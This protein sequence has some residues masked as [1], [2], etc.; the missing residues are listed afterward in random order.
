VRAWGGIGLAFTLWAAVG[1]VAAAPTRCPAANVVIDAADSG[2][3]DAGCRAAS[4]AAEFLAASG[5]ATGIPIEIWFVD[6]M[7]D[8][9][10]DTP[11]VGCYVRAE[12]RIYVLTFAR[13]QQRRLAH[14]VTID[15]SVHMGLVAHEVAHRIVAANVGTDRLSTVAHEYI[16]YVTM[17]A[18]MPENQRERVLKQIPGSGFDSERQISVTMYLL[19]PVYFGAQAYRHFQ[20]PEI[21]RSFLASVLNRQALVE[22]ETR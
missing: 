2:D 6:V 20:K 1:V 4:A 15:R 14:D 13:C 5:L 7:P 8:V 9:A 11:A 17:Y 3:F 19:D 22:D 10:A 18:T 12:N 21:G 16:A